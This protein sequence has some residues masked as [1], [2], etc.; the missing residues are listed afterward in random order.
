MAGS[1]RNPRAATKLKQA[2]AA[3]KVFESGYSRGGKAG[4][5][6]RRDLARARYRSI[7]RR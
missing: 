2:K 6:E 7:S 3:A 4:V 1:K 5:W